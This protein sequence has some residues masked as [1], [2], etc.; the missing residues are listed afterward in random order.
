M[1]DPIVGSLKINNLPDIACFTNFSDF[2]QAF[3]KA[4]VVELPEVAQGVVVST[5]EPNP[6]LAG[7][8]VQIDAAGNFLGIYVYSGG[9]WTQLNLGSCSNPDV[10]SGALVVCDG[11]TNTTLGTAAIL[12]IP[13]ASGVGD[14]VSFQTPYDLRNQSINASVIGPIL[15]DVANTSE[16]SAASSI[17]VT[18]SSTVRSKSVSIIGSAI[19]NGLIQTPAAKD[20]FLIQVSLKA[21]LDNVSYN[22]LAVF[23]RHFYNES[24][25]AAAPFQA[26]KQTVQATYAGGLGVS[27]APGGS[28]IIYFKCEIVWIDTILATSVG[29][30]INAVGD[31]VVH[32]I[33][34]NT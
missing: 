3:V 22:D 29:K 2:I 24:L 18:N 31:L 17:T 5:T 14:E 12:Q 20:Q 33:E 34:V 21:S 28:Q 1:A 23:T 25:A 27:I 10:A 11:G 8:W 13:V 19:A 7:I 9:A 15:I 26:N 4:V 30:Y 16:L 6:T 32:V